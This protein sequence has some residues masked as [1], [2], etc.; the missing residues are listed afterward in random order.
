MDVCLIY[1]ARLLCKY[2]ADTEDVFRL[3]SNMPGFPLSVTCTYHHLD[4]FATL[5][6][7]GAKPDLDHLSHLPLHPD[8]KVN[9][10]IPHIIMKY[11]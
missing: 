5:L 7:C 1:L 6:V 2:G 8:A 11:G 3:V 10:S 9:C 4:C